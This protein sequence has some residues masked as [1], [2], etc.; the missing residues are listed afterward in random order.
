MST[1][2]I[3]LPKDLEDFVSAKVASGEYAHA[4][5]VIRDGLRLLIR[6]EAE[7]L[8]RLRDAIQKGI[9]SADRGDVMP[10]AQAFK[11]A[12]RRGLAMFNA[13]KTRR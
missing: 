3:S 7:K 13:R 11:E 6:E 5:E 10:A 12:R 9:E 8:E 2:N 4:S 1:R